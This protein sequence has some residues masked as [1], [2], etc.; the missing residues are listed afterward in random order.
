LQQI[1]RGMG[2]GAIGM[3]LGLLLQF[4]ARLIIARYG[5]EANYGL[6]SLALVVLNF[7]MVLSCLG[8]Q[9]GV[10][11]Y[12]AFHRGRA[13]ESEIGKTIASTLQVS[14]VTGC[15]TGVL[16]F[17]FAQVIA[18]NIFHSSELTMVLKIFAIGLPFLTLV[19]IMSAI[20]RGFNKIEPQAL[21]QSILLNALFLVLLIGIILLNMIF[22]FFFYA[23]LV[24]IIVTFAAMLIYAFRKIPRMVTFEIGQID[25]STIKILLAFSL[26][27]FVT[28]IVSII[29]F[30][31]DTL[32]LGYFR[33]PD[34][35]G[36]YNA[37]YPLAYFITVPLAS[38]ILIYIPV[39]S[40]LFAQGLITEVKRTY[41]ISTKWL[42]AL[43][44]PLWLV[45]FLFP[46]AVLNVVFGE[47]Y[48]YGPASSVLRILAS[49]F[50]VMNL[51][52]LGSCIFLASGNSKFI[53]WS[54]VI[55]AL[56]NILLCI[57]LIPIAG[58][59]G[60][61]TASAVSLTVLNLIISIRL[62]LAKKIQP[63]SKNL[64]KPVIVSFVL[65]FLFQFIIRQFIV[66][67]WWILPLIFIFYFVLYG[68]I[69]LL[70]RSFDAEDIAILLD[71]EK[72]IGLNMDPVK[73]ILKKF[74]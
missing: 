64:V 52:G 44:L 8:L 5:L 14:I 70:T 45:M 39:I 3:Y 1:A 69:T 38:F 62:Y 47:V 58:A 72:T 48:A 27:V 57:V 9:D 32:M 53:M 42:V 40:S 12:I 13:D 54:G 35:V 11:R 20:F 2:I 17:F 71:I 46:D 19:N 26:P 65:A 22:Q 10:A 66:I 36:L 43:T 33:S 41:I 31:A 15:I 55:A 16:L 63:F 18:V 6:F 28:A 34:V 21:F 7:A 59:I 25:I 29:I 68:I 24:A 37:A 30:N 56:I 49:S 51:L 60:A 73:K 4:F 50:M 67:T 74:I 61:A 23:Y